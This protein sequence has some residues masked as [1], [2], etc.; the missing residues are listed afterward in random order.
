M[1]EPSESAQARGPSLLAREAQ[2]F[3]VELSDLQLGQLIRYAEMLMD[4][5]RRVNLTSIRDPDEVAVKHFVDSLAVSRFMEGSAGRLMD[6][7]SGAGF[8]GLVLKVAFPEWDVSLCDALRKRTDFLKAVAS[9]LG[10]SGVRV[11]HARAEELGRHPD[12]RDAHALVTARAVARL[13]TLVEWGLPFV[14]PGG[15]FVAMKGPSAREEI[16]EAD[17]AIRALRG[18]TE[19]V[20]PYALPAGMGARVLVVIRKRAATPSAFPRR[21][22]EAKRTPLNSGNP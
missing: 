17:A 20:L 3:G 1:D 10:L 5:G 21:S 2:N 14:A 15:R 13:Q 9:E 4:W 16:R 22:G 12:F 6:V 11:A 19:D 7:G 18:E 8:P